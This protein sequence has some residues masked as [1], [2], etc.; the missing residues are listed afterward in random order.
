MVNER[1]WRI[2]TPEAVALDLEAA[3]L[4]SRV[5][6]ELV[7]LFVLQVVFG[8]IATVDGLLAG[9]FGSDNALVVT[10]VIIS[11]FLLLLAWPIAWEVGT[12]GRSL[13]K[14]AVGLRV[15]T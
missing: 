4:A 11:S 7:D 5:L 13:G 3:G 14:M 1:T 12:H 9:T 10:L 6:A 2:V 15:V 8:A